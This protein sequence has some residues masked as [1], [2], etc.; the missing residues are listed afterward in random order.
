MYVV[1]V[2]AANGDNCA[3][4]TGTGC[5]DCKYQQ[6]DYNLVAPLDV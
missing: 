2:C 1:Q 6:W 4:H 3:A 5:V